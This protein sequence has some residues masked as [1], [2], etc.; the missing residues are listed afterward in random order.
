VDFRAVPA[1][2]DTVLPDWSS[3]EISILRLDPSARAIFAALRDGRPLPAAGTDLVNTPTSPA[4]IATAVLDASSGNAAGEVEHV[5]SISGLDVAPGIVP[6]ERGAGIL[7]HETAIVY[8]PGHLEEAQ[9]V[10]QFFPD[11][12]LRRV[13]HGS[14]WDVAVVVT[15]GYEPKP[16]GGGSPPSCI[17]PA[18]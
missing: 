7:G 8:P 17:A 11:L 18:A 12:P 15:P 2:P 10:G 16:L 5:L 4:N 3:S 13:A 1:V 6:F 9:V 14:P